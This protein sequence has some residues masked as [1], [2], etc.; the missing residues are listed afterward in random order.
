MINIYIY[1]Y[2]NKYKINLFI[3]EFLIS[4]HQTQDFVFPEARIRKPDYGLLFAQTRVAVTIEAALLRGGAPKDSSVVRAGAPP[5]MRSILETVFPTP[6]SGISL[7]SWNIEFFPLLVTT[8]V[9]EQ[10]VFNFLKIRF[11]EIGY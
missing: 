3:H 6:E 2:K 8:R 1:I 5:T 9:L 7:R 11:L 4:G 10:F